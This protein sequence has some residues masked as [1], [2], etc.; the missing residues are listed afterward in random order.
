M[1]KGTENEGRMTGVRA[2]G[3][4]CGESS[5]TGA[6]TMKESILWGKSQ[7]NSLQACMTYV[8]VSMDGRVKGLHFSMSKKWRK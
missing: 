5:Q 8:S 1:L 3:Q 2:E 6:K 7:K 4:L